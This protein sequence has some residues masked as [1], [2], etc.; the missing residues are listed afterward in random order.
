MRVQSWLKC[1]LCGF[2]V[3][4]SIINMREINTP[5]PMALRRGCVEFVSIVSEDRHLFKKK[6]NTALKAQ[7]DAAKA[8]LNKIDK[9]K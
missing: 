2:I 7:C 5:A 9:A 1:L 8:M 4:F 6:A 3:Y